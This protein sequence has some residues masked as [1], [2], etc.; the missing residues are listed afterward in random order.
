MKYTRNTLLGSL[1]KAWGGDSNAEATAHEVSRWVSVPRGSRRRPALRPPLCA[2]TSLV[3]D[4]RSRPV[5]LWLTRRKRKAI[6]YGRDYCLGNYLL[7][8]ETLE[9]AHELYE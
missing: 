3:S 9:F 4:E 2:A 5:S 7:E 6:R 1:R 8:I